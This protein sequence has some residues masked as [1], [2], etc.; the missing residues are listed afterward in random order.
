MRETPS[1]PVDY[2]I[3]AF[4]FDFDFDFGAYCLY[5]QLFF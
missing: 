5:M 2:H 1:P 4:D 3:I